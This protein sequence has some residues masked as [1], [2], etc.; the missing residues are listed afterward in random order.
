M[1]LLDE[2][3]SN[4]ERA[5]KSRKNKKKLAFEA[6]MVTAK[7]YSANSTLGKAVAKI[8]KSFSKIQSLKV[9]KQGQIFL[10]NKIVSIK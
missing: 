5:Q 6:E 1:K 10:L 2:R 8:R 3:R 4:R 7:G 9:Q